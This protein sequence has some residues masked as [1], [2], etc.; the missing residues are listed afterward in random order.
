MHTLCTFLGERLKRV[1]MMNAR[2][3][4][5]IIFRELIKS[6]TF[7]ECKVTKKENNVKV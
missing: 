3:C 4:G 2:L 7:D 5:Q 1:P 6:E